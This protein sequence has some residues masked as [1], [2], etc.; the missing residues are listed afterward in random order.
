MTSKFNKV[1]LGKK[2]PYYLNPKNLFL[3]LS[4][5]KLFFIITM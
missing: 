4:D 5:K 2:D 3:N 1:E